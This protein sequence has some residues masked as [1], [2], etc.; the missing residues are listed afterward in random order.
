MN[1]LKDLPEKEKLKGDF[2]EDCRLRGMTASTIQNYGSNI[3]IFY[4]FL[5]MN[6]I[7]VENVDRDALK[8]F[9]EYLRDTREVSHKRIENYFS[10]LSCLFEYLVFEQ[11]TDINII[12]SIRKRYLRTYK[13]NGNKPSERKLISI[14]DMARLVNS[15]LAVRDRAILMLF[16]KTGIRKGELMQIDIDDINW[17]EQSITLKPIAKRSNR[18]VF[19]DDECTRALRRWMLIRENI[20]PNNPALFPGENKERICRNAVY[21]AVVKHATRLGLHNSESKKMEDHFTPHCC[22]HWFT[23]HLRRS[24][25]KR[26]FIQE[27]RGDERKEAIDIYDH[28]EKDELRKSYLSHIPQFGT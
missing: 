3:K 9:L 23:T 21:N 17:I 19:F 4:E 24:G 8:L 26:E 15:T 22:R 13:K 2:I 11:F 28:I 5:D 20:K 18:V 6:N 25:M 7:D 16:A 10:A 1:V 14:E 12:L 27:L